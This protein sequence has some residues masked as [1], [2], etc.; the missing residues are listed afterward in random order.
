ME[1]IILAVLVY[2]VLVGAAAL[3]R[4]CRQ[5]WDFRRQ[6]ERR[7][8]QQKLADDR[9]RAERYTEQR[10]LRKQNQLMQMALLQLEQAPDFRRAAHFA[11]QAEAV[12]A[13]FRQ[14]QFTRF[15]GKLVSHY[16]ERLSSGA[17]SETLY[18]SL[19]D[20]VQALG[21]ARFEADYIQAE[22][23]RQLDRPSPRSQRSFAT[24][25]AALQQE[26]QRRLEALA[27]LANLSPDLREQL[28]EAEDAR[29]SEAMFELQRDPEVGSL[30]P[31]QGP[32]DE[33]PP[34][35]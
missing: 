23:E 16:A 27:A 8:A 11:R 18:S 29:F 24:A 17:E 12:A 25:M 14:R 26:H 22:A 19:A 34:I 6:R 9:R 30:Q 33:T 31:T 32:A 15:R 3:G 21:V 1:L 20:L 2:G 13:A 4:W 28:A 7:A 35:V 10:R 5:R